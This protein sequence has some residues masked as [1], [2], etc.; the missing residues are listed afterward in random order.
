MIYFLFGKDSYR[1]REKLNEL[2]GFFAQ[3]N[4]DAEIFKIDQDNFEPAKIDELAKS[5]GL[6][7]KKYLVVCDAVLESKEA[8]KYFEKN[9]ETISGSQ[10]VFIFRENEPDEKIL[11]L[12]KKYSE[13]TQEFRPLSGA[14]LR[15]WIKKREVVVN[16]IEEVIERCGSDLWCITNELAKGQISGKK[17]IKQKYNP[18]A[19]CDA[20]AVKNK[21]RAWSLL[22][23]ALLNGVPEEEI[24]YKTAWQ[25][26]ILLMVMRGATAGMHPFVVQKNLR[27]V[28]NFT[29]E[30]LINDSYKLLKTYHDVRNGNEEFSI[31]LEKF[32]LEM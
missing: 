19:I 30:E 13:K 21:V 17:L 4:K 6:F 20:V 24:F 16:I 11:E 23:E 5:Q 15:E 18:F 14:K 10:N 31:G 26:K 8:V 29:E 27:A 2:A 7:A 9:I 28:N 12:F 25:I 32:L 22:Q 1:S 3:K